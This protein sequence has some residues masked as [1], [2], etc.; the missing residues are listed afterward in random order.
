LVGP[1][2]EKAWKNKEPAVK[3][4]DV[5]WAQSLKPCTKGIREEF[6]EFI[7]KSKNSKFGNSRSKGSLKSAWWCY[8]SAGLLLAAPK[9]LQMRIESS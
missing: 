3:R 6:K 8:Y 5:R 4:R 9:L 1:G 2:N 7:K